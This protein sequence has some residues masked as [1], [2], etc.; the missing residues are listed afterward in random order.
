MV[1]F[2]PLRACVPGEERESTSNW[3]FLVVVLQPI[4]FCVLKKRANHS[5]WFIFLCL[6]FSRHIAHYGMIGNVSLP[7]ASATG[8]R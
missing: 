3:H 8:G 7:A 2:M 5:A 1:I 4:G 6:T